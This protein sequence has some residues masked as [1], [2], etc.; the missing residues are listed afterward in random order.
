MILSFSSKLKLTKLVLTPELAGNTTGTN[1]RS[2]MV[3]ILLRRQLLQNLLILN[4]ALMKSKRFLHR[5]IHF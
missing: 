1:V 4:L 3:D 2:P 5:E